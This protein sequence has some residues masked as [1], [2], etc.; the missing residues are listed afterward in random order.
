M[1]V[2]FSEFLDYELLEGDDVDDIEHS[3]HL[4]H[5]HDAHLVGNGAVAVVTHYHKHCFYGLSAQSLA[6][7]SVLGDI[8]VGRQG[9]VKFIGLL[10]VRRRNN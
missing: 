4:V 1:L 6:D 9:E 3:F 5:D 10:A 2:A 7:I 8:R